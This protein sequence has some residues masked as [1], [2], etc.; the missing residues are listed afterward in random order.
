M[1]NYFSRIE[2][3][4]YNFKRDFKVGVNYTYS[5]GDHW[6]N[7]GEVYFGKKIFLSENFKELIKNND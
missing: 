3:M 1:Y 6:S 4:N 7:F 5:D 2:A